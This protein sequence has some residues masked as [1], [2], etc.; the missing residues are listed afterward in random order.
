MTSIQVE[1]QKKPTQKERLLKVLKTGASVSTKDAFL[2]LGIGRLAHVVFEL[3]ADGYDITT[4]LVPFQNQ[5]GRGHY[6]TY[7]L[8]KERAVLLALWVNGSGA[9]FQQV[10]KDSGLGLSDFTNALTTLKNAGTVEVGKESGWGKGKLFFQITKNV[11][12]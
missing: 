2:S 10:M 6:G 3:K 7:F 9:D 5:F 12:A 4:N 11:L 1:K 8:T